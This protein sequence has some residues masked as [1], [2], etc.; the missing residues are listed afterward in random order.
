M[1]ENV[2]A[3]TGD[4]RRPG[5]YPIVHPVPLRLLLNAAGGLGR[6]A[7]I[8]QVEVTRYD[9]S[10]GATTTD[11]RREVLDLTKISLDSVVVRPGDMVRVAT[12]VTTREWRG[13]PAG[14]SASARLIRYSSR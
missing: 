10:V 3:I 4:V 12:R 13:G 14:R 8:S 7:D 2:S 6:S 1:L 5:L 9:A 11:I